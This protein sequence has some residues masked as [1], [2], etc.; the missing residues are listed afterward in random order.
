[1]KKT[2]WLVC[3]VA[4]IAVMVLGT[5]MMASAEEGGLTLVESY[6]KDGQKNA[7]A[8]NIGVKLTFSAPV[9]LAANQAENSKC[10]TLTSPE[11]DVDIKVYYNPDVPEQ[12]LVL[13]DYG[14]DAT[15]RARQAK[16][17]EEYI[18]SISGAFKD[19]EG[20]L[21]GKD[22]KITFTTANVRRNNI[23]YFVLM[24]VM[25]FGMF[26]FASRQAKAQ[27]VAD[28]EG[29]DATAEAFNPY[30]EA[31][32]TG[33]TVAQVIA[34][35][36]KEVA[37]QQA[38]ESKRSAKIEMIEEEYEDEDS[39]F[40]RVKGPRPI[41]AAGST[42]ITGRKAEAEARAA[43]KAAEEERIAKRKT[44]NKKK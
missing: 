30:K 12:V 33:K 24:G 6:P 8:D 4:I 41:S 44:K 10:F 34:E 2:G 31:K 38:K 20:N 37:K 26:F 18:L 13:Q 15:I 11:G 19:N 27:A 9:N 35:H 29:G 5:V 3:I 7:A 22:Q 23:V 16:G 32:K 1:M 28:V 43:A 42:Y 17:N 39:G 40:Y 21:L 14:E 25:M 36:D